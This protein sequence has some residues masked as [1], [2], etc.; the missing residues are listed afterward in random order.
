DGVDLLEHHLALELQ[1]TGAQHRV[2]DQVGE[3]IER[4]RQIGVEHARVKRRGVTR[5]VGVERAAARLEGEGDLLG[6]A[7]RGPLELH[8]LEQV[9]HAHLGARLM[10]A[11]AAH[12]DADRGRA[13][14]RHPFRQHQDP[15][16]RGGLV[17]LPVEPDRLH[18]RERA[19]AVSGLSSSAFRESRMRPRSS[20]SSSLTRTWSP[21]FTTSSVRSVRPCC[22]SE[23]CNSPS[24]PGRISTKAPNAVVLFTT[25]SY[26]LPT[27]GVWIIAATMSRARSP[28]SP[29]AEMV[30]MP[31]SST[32]ISAP[33]CSWMLRIVL[34]LGPIRSLILS[35]GIWIV[36]IRGAYLESDERGSGIALSMTSRMCSRAFLAL[37][38]A[39]AM[40][41]KSSPSILM[42]IWIE[43]TPVLVTATLKSMSPRWSSVPRMLVS[44]ATCFPSLIRPIA[45]PAP[46]PDIGTRTSN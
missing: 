32:L 22:N 46:G 43:V 16:W 17:D 21:F 7:A 19:G 18:H 41:P 12:P 28:P 29:T 44:T 2:T 40:I 11:G 1:I 27:S 15:A 3:H 37:S 4:A 24:T 33:V 23:M 9:G 5:G 30:T 38:S 36:M 25:P 45:T 31:L 26:T 6:G 20:T 14:A 10:R 42:S 34:P 35:T 13:H 8:V 39:S